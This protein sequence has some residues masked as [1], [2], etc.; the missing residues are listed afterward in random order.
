MT[1]QSRLLLSLGAIALAG[2]VA[3][4]WLA[5]QYEKRAAAGSVVA[6]GAETRAVRLV[7]AYLALGGAAEPGADALREHGIS[8]E[9]YATVREAISAYTSSRTVAD[10][11]LKGAIEA[12]A[13]EIR[14]LPGR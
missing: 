4:S 12:R 7:A 6:E 11:V 9:E 1:R 14:A 5:S 3:L 8:R 2:T 13:G 10:P